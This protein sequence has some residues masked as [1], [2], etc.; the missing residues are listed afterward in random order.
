[1]TCHL[2]ADKLEIE[3]EIEFLILLDR[4]GWLWWIEVTWR[5]CSCVASRWSYFTFCEQT[6][7]R[8]PGVEVGR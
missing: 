1:M 3:T 5:S 4:K 8:C 7:M 2:A 6:L